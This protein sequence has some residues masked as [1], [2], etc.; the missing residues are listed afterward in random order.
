M[1]GARPALVT[2]ANGFIG[3][4]LVSHLEERSQG[5]FKWTRQTGDL[6]DAGH[7]SKVLKDLNPSVIFHLAAVSPQQDVQDWK[8]V[9]QETAMFTNLLDAS[10]A[11]CT[12]L[13]AGSM[14]EFGRSGTFNEND[15]CRPDSFYG[16]AKNT[17]VNAALAACENLKRDVRVARLFGV[18]GP[19]EGSSRLVPYLIRQFKA[20]EPVLLGDGN[21]LR[22][23]IHVDDVCRILIDLTEPKRAG[24]G[25]V[26][27]GT[28]KGILLRD[29]C[30]SIAQLMNAEERLLHFNARPARAID[31]A[32]LV[33][34][35]RKLATLTQVPKQHWPNGQKIAD[36]V[37]GL[38]SR[39]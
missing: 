4:R 31:Q 39:P 15:L 23:F 1:T 12:L 13:I 24:F 7:V 14:A 33:A 34:D 22:D 26:H 30:Q 21:Q 9:A 6:S 36:Y 5:I 8:A 19:G 29:I 18:Y 25:L 27:V 38:M 28:G 32:V 2:G 10:S 16:L 17:V 11:D 35:T 3:R 37:A 20:A